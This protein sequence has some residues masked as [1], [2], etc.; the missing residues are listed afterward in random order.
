MTIP[1]SSHSS[2][3]I[4]RT[5]IMTTDTAMSA[6]SMAES[7]MSLYGHQSYY[8]LILDPREGR[9]DMAP[10]MLV[11]FSRISTIIEDHLHSKDT[12]M[13]S[14]R[15][16]LGQRD[17]DVGELAGGQCSEF[18]FDNEAAETE[19]TENLWNQVLMHKDTRSSTPSTRSNTSTVM[20]E[21]SNVISIAFIPGVTHRNVGPA[22]NTQAIIVNKRLP[23]SDTQAMLWNKPLPSLPS[24]AFMPL[25]Q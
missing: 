1:A 25:G 19:A 14:D 9:F 6:R 21:T 24:S 4:D 3:A 7:I 17:V 22:L 11:D 13:S 16:R 12:T 20:T 15:H 23:S 8:Q 18:N 5:S 2:L 10:E